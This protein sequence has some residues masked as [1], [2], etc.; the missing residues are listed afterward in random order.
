MS[1]VKKI[2]K[3]K[4]K[5]N[6]KHSAFS[7]CLKYLKGVTIKWSLVDPLGDDN[8]I[9]DSVIGH[10]NPVSRL[11][12]HLI[13]PHLNRV[14]EEMVL[15]YRVR[16]RVCFDHDGDKGFREAVIAYEALINAAKPEL[17]DTIEQIFSES[18]MNFY[19]HTEYKL[20]ILGRGSAKKAVEEVA[21]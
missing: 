6:K 21:A 11:K 16:V 19:T 18:N 17:D 12:M 14:I 15:L 13:K 3:Q 1:K 2:A 7:V 20:E 5:R 10:S 4:K 8:N 9:I